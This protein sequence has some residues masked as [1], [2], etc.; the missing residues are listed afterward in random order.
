[1]GSTRSASIWSRYLGLSQVKGHGG[2]I[3]GMAVDSLGSGLFL[4]FGTL[5][6]LRA[7]H[8]PLAVVG[9]SLTAAQ[10]LTL[11]FPLALAPLIDRWGPKNVVITGNI[12]S[13]CAYA[14][15]VFVHNQPELLVAAFVAS[16]GNVMFWTAT[17]ALIGQAI[18]P[19]ERRGWFALQTATRNA[20]YGV[21]GLLGAVAV[22]LSGSTALHIIVIAD[23]V[24][25][26]CAATAFWRWHAPAPLSAAV[27]GQETKV[28][29]KAGYRDILTDP[30]WWSL[31]GVNLVF[32]LCAIT[33]DVLL[34]VYL[35]DNLHQPAWLAGLLYALNTFLVVATQT[36]ITGRTRR[37]RTAWV[38]RAAALGWAVS[39]ALL[40]ALV[41][42][43]PAFAVPV[44]VISVVLFTVAQLLQGPAI[45]A[46]AVDLAP[47]DAPGRHMAVFQLSWNASVAL[48]PAILTG[49]LSLGAS[50]PW[51]VLIVL[52]AV[53]ALGLTPGVRR[54]EPVEQ[55]A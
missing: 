7:T 20:G 1:M 34:A 55:A 6:F 52:C 54:P 14:G 45:N 24:S 28:Q 39:F 4:P 2:L 22:G 38:L 26:A 23:A 18:E 12:I 44:L 15:Y 53:T 29:P 48:A 42:V 51:V 41:I 49:L 3:A 37:L 47:R 8:L 31:I 33:L 32:V 21:G 25:F 46:L 50:W 43:P 17:R 19:S 10:L 27:A 11:F 30:R 36:L 9:S 40:W 5:Y 35:V 13:A 16:I